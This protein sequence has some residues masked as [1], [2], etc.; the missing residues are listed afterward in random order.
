MPYSTYSPTLLK[1][2]HLQASLK[3]SSGC[4]KS[5]Y[6]SSYNYYCLDL[7]HELGEK[8]SSS[9]RDMLQCV[10]Q[11]YSALA[12]MLMYVKSSDKSCGFYRCYLNPHSVGLLF[13]YAKI[14]PLTSSASG[15]LAWRALST[16]QMLTWCGVS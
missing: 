6:T 2:E 5:R 3:K 7:L 8:R 15:N 13:G 1:N 12:Q 10:L 16:S 11:S 14:V 9:C 4:L